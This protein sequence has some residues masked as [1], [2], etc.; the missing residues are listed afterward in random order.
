MHITNQVKNEFHSLGYKDAKLGRKL[1]D[2]DCYILIEA[3]GIVKTHFANINNITD[4]YLAKLKS[5]NELLNI[6]SKALR[7]WRKNKKNQTKLDEIDEAITILNNEIIDLEK[8][9]KSLKLLIATNMDDEIENVFE[10]L[11]YQYETGYL[12]YKYK[13]KQNPSSEEINISAITCEIIDQYTRNLEFGKE[14]LD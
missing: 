2:A 7:I 13:N 11:L 10:L 4:N 8:D 3:K 6:D 9:I 5:K 14:N 1:S 12:T